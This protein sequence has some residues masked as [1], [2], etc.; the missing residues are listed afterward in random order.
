VKH[1]IAPAAKA[2]VARPFG[3]RLAGRFRPPG[4][5]IL[6]YHRISAP[7]DRFPGLPASTFAE[8]M[9]WVASACT[10]VGPEQLLDATLTTRSARPPILVTFD[11]GYVGFRRHAYPVLR[12]LGIPC[13]VFLA[14]GYIDDP[15]TLFWWDALRAAVEGARVG[16]V[17]LPWV[18]GDRYALDSR[19]S[20]E[21][22]IRAAKDHLKDQP[23]V[24]HEAQ[25]AELLRRLGV[26]AESL[27]GEREMMDWDD[28]RATL[29]VLCPGGHTHTHPIL[30]SV[31][32]EEIDYEVRTCSERVR[33]ETG[34]TPRY[35]AYPNGRSRD[36]DSRA[37]G[38]L[39]RHGF[40]LAFTTEEGVNGPDAAPMALRRF[41]GDGTVSELAWRLSAR[42]GR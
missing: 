8:Q 11:D 5:L 26:A 18:P 7:E 32:D 38:A 23:H 39:R 25:L 28:V 15:T 27:R 34:L 21:R 22:L 9:R 40:D 31:T 36:F 14:T 29:D 19:A 1:L 42:A 4:L 6:T 10:P 2:F 20:R 35:F 3:W 17:E 16:S 30:S 13:V 37:Q 41:A 24:G 12:E 33:A